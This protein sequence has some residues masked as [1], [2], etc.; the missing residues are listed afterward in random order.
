MDGINKDANMEE[1]QP[2]PGGNLRALTD[3]GL[4]FNPKACLLGLPRE[5][6]DMVMMQ[7]IIKS[8]NTITM[9]PNFGCHKNEISASQPSICCVNYQLRAETLPT[10]Y[11]ANIFTAQLDNLADLETAKAWLEAIGD[12][13]IAHLKR[14]VM[15]G[16]TRV[17]IGHMISKRWIR[18]MLHL[19]DG[20]LEMESLDGSYG[21]SVHGTK[22]E[23]VE[24]VKAVEDL[25]VGFRRAIESRGG[26]PL[27][28]TSLAQMMDGFSMLCTGY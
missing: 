11:S 13:N 1:Q 20:K 4:P 7:L 2:N 16:W 26:K 27:D 18:V 17:A 19:K 9:L 10:F 21:T 12:Q 25:R 8:T 5:L 28:A 3:H 15:C 24:V 14:V 23:S 22:E 6:R